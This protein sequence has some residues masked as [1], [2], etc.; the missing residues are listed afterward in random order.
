MKH[1]ENMLSTPEKVISH[2]YKVAKHLSIKINKTFGAEGSNILTSSGTTAGQDIMHFHIHIIPRYRTS[3][4]VIRF[5]YLDSKLKDPQG[6]EKRLTTLKNLFTKSE[7][8]R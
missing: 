1:Y 2:M 4:G 5:Y 3:Q 7:I 6:K 8:K